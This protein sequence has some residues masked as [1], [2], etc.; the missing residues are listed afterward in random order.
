MVASEQP[1]A[2]L[3][4]VIEAL[5]AL[6]RHSHREAACLSKVRDAAVHIAKHNAQ[7]ARGIDANN[8]AFEALVNVVD[9]GERSYF[10]REEWDWREELNQIKAGNENAHAELRQV[11]EGGER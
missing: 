6:L 3:V 2:G 5:G 4:V 7:A 11:N 9:S 10:E 1:L 8:Q